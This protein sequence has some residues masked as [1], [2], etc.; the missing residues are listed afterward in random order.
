[1]DVTGNR[2]VVMTGTLLV[3]SKLT[4]GSSETFVVDVTTEY[5]FYFRLQDQKFWILLLHEM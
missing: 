1:M 3:V 5:N 4:A 2:H